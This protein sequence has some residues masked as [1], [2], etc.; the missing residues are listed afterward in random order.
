R[1]RKLQSCLSRLR[2]ATLRKAL[3]AELVAAGALREEKERFLVL[4]HR[5]RWHP[6]PDSPEE[7]IIEHL[8][9]YT[10]TVDEQEP[11]TRDDLMLSLLRATKLLEV[12]WQPE[13]LEGLLRAR[14]ERRTDR[15]P[16]GRQVHQAVETALAAAV[17]AMAAAS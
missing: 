3:L 8:R 5:R 15:A 1:P 12:V 17:A 7:T 16:I 6:A 11:P 9:N 14:I 2:Y 10:A 4:F 13:E